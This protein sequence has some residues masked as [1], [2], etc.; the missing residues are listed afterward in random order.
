MWSLGLCVEPPT[1]FALDVVCGFCI[2]LHCCIC[3]RSHSLK[4]MGNLMYARYNTKM[5]PF[6]LSMT[7][8]PFRN[9]YV[10]F[11]NG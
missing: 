5:S 11:T 4:T 1:S 6:S 3:A 2:L 10:N 9:R 8:E 7:R